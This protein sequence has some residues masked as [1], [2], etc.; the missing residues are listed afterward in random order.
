MRAIT[1]PTAAVD[2]LRSRQGKVIP[3]VEGLLFLSILGKLRDPSNTE[4]DCRANRDRLGYP[5]FKSHGFRKTVATVLDHAGLSARE[6]AEWLG[7]ENP[8][9]TQD[10]YVSRTVG[11]SRTARYRQ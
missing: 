9:L 6:V 5:G 8:S 11:T 7:H 2:L 10:V 4:A 3:I 1:V